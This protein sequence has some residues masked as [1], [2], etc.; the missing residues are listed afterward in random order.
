MSI[1]KY[2]NLIIEVTLYLFCSKEKRL[3]VMVLLK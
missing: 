3:Y 2:I 1:Y